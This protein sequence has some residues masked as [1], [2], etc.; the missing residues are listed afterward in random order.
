MP[1]TPKRERG[2]PTVR[3][4]SEVSGG[5]VTRDHLFVSYAWEDGALAEWLVRKLTA[6]GYSVWCDRFKILGGERWPKDVD[7]AI[8]TRTFRMLGLL[9]EYSLE[10]PN[11]CKER[12]M[13]LT[14]SKERKEED[15]L[16]PLNIDGRLPSDIGWEMSDINFIPFQSWSTGL[17]QLLNKLESISAPRPLGERGR[18]VAVETFLP[19]NVL[20]DEEE[21][22]YSNCLR[23]VRIPEK[24]KHYRFTRKLAQFELQKLE[25]KW[26]FMQKGT[27]EALAFSSLRNEVLQE[28]VP[29]CAIEELD[30]LEWKGRSLVDGLRTNDLISSLIKK[31]MVVKCLD[32]GLVP[33]DTL[34][35]GFFPVGILPND[36]LSFSNYTGK[37]T[38]V[39]V[40]GERAFGKGRFRYQLGVGFWVRSNVTDSLVVETKIQLRVTDPSNPN[41]TAHAANARRKKVTKSWWNHEWLSRQFAIVAFL[42]GSDAA[43]TIGDADGEKLEI[44]AE[45]LSAPVTPSIDDEALEP[46]AAKVAAMSLAQD[47]ESGEDESDDQL[48]VLEADAD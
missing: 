2:K 1:S 38:H 37:S 14:L 45:L 5:S 31:S 44:S 36:S 33:N 16:I 7:R 34:T 13:A 41:L 40:L 15:F 23:V 43:I 9:S 42:K 48:T 46:F 30:P 26:P 32:R 27:A 18:V 35:A 28:A 39:M 29:E 12:Q 21:R 20:R 19:R 10:K 3:Q 24:I 47:S 17:A 6:E 11:P 25:R 22:L 8:K 4:A